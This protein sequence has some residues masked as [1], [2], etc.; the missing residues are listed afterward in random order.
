MRLPR[1]SRHNIPCSMCKVEFS[2]TPDQWS[3]WRHKKPT[4]CSRDC[5]KARHE[6]DALARIPKQPCTTCGE[7]FV[8]SKSQR[9]KIKRRP[10]TGLYCST[11][12]LYKSRETNPR[13][14]WT[15]KRGDKYFTSH[16]CGFCG[17]E[18]VPS[19]RQ[20]QWGALHPETRS[21]CSVECDQEWRSAWMKD[22]KLWEKKVHIYGPQNPRWKH[23]LYSST[24]LE[25][26]KLRVKINRL[27]REGAKA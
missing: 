7:L 13:K 12:C 9:D 22:A 1:L 10:N 16:T 24:A 4:Y 27:I 17:G 11:E 21:F 8:L 19:P 25:V 14:I 6:A 2:P 15:K 18:F 26:D 20:R 5:V 3:R 23:G